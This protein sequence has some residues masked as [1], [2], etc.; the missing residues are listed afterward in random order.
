LNISKLTHNVGQ[1][2]S[3]YLHRFRLAKD[4]AQVLIPP[5]GH[6]ISLLPV[7]VVRNDCYT[8]QGLEASEEETGGFIHQYIEMMSVEE[9]ECQIGKC[10]RRHP[11]KAQTM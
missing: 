2:F 7:D 10:E 5:M 11:E 9:S 4:T 1:I 8:I 6:R 3:P